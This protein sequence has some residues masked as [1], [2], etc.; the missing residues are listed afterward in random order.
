MAI[1][2]TDIVLSLDRDHR[3]IED[4]L[5]RFAAEPRD[6]WGEAFCELTEL[7]VRHEVAEEETVYPG[8]RRAS[9]DTEGIVDARIAEQS[10]AEELL[11]QMEKMETTS[12]EFADAF[13]RLRA[14]VLSH[15]QREEE[16]VFPL[17]RQYLDLE[18][19]SAMAGRYERA[20]AAAPT[21]PHPHAP[22]TPPG[23]LL[24]GPV[25]AVLD[26]VRDAVRQATA[27][28]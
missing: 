18:E 8:L 1:Q 3:Q 17:L 24:L 11:S 7:L 26:R 13:A 12:A 23:N 20:L 10:E 19:R 6:R 16:S 4:H 9:S 27:D 5:D 14:A 15:A 22:D 28:A 25:A 21:H 2:T